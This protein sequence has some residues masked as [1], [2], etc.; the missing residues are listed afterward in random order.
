MS[1]VEQL[2]QSVFRIKPFELDPLE[3]LV[4]MFSEQTAAKIAH[5]TSATSCSDTSAIP[6]ML[7]YYWIRAFRQEYESQRMYPYENSIQPSRLSEGFNRRHRGGIG[8]SG[9][10]AGNAGR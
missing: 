7:Y 6:G 4:L 9:L 5:G 8:R 10:A 2:R 1:R 3:G